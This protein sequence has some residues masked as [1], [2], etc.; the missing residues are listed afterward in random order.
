MRFA[1]RVKLIKQ[2]KFDVRVKSS[3]QRRSLQQGNKYHTYVR[4]PQIG[5]SPDEMGTIFEWGN[6]APK[7]EI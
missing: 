3:K 2:N 6:L 5:Q 1:N 7:I 4:R